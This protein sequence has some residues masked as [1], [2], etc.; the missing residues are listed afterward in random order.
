MAEQLNPAGTPVELHPRIV[1]RT[2][3]L[4]GTAEVHEAASAGTRAADRGQPDFLAALATNEM[5]EDLTVEIQ[6]PREEGIG[7][8]SRAIAG[9]DAIQLEVANPGAAFGQ[10]VLYVSE[11]G[12]VSWH[13]PEGTDDDQPT[14]RGSSTLTY[15]IPRAV[16]PTAGAEGQ[17]GLAGAIGKKILKVLAFRLVREGSKWVGRKFAERLEDQHRPHR[18]HLVRPGPGGP[19]LTEAPPAL[20]RRWGDERTLLLVHGTFSSIRGG[21]GSFRPATLEELHTRY[22]GRVLAFDH[23]TVSRSPV[24]N[25]AWLGDLLRA[26]EIRLNVDLITH[27]RGGLVG[28]VLAEESNLAATADVLTVDRAAFV[29]CPH[30]GTALADVNNHSAMVDRIS[31]LLQFVPDNGVTD[32]L[33]VAIAVLKQIAVGIAEGLPGLMSMD[34]RGTFLTEALNVGAG[35]SATYFAAGSNFEPAK[36]SSLGQF[37]FDAGSD[38]VFRGAANDLVV[39]RDGA[40]LVEGPN[41]FSIADRLL[42]DTPAAVH[43]S[44]YWARDEMNDAFLRWLAKP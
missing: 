34:P 22:G 8:G 19:V 20:L 36:D 13:F 38:L 7:T 10:I 32:A 28:R 12:A 14:V 24:D 43:H 27:S 29:A 33:E 37:A 39:P 25:A 9:D 2:P 41:G 17:R 3:G 6:K 23:P 31:N 44:G 42:F 1:I 4:T 21:F 15:R 11:N 30:A 5:I 35:T 16:T 26:D 40:Y 18:L